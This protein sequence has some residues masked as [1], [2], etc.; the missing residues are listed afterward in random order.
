[1]NDLTTQENAPERP[2]AADDSRR[3]F[4]PL[5]AWPAFLLA[6]LML[7]A[8]FGPGIPAG[9][10]AKY[11]MGAVFGPLLGCLLLGIWLLAASLGT[12]GGSMFRF[13]GLDRG[14]H[15][16]LYPCAP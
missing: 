10:A 11:W 7:A 8:R 6:F 1:M 13:F 15:N 16:Y 2:S 14:P 3:P 12:W 5:R 9:G 4:R